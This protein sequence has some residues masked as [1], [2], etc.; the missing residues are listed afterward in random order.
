MF[1]N[2]AYFSAQNYRTL[3]YGDVLVPECWPL[4]GPLE[5]MDGLLFFG[6]S[7]SSE[8]PTRSV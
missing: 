7:T 2:L 5:A 3:W 8:L 4:M 1:L 6:L